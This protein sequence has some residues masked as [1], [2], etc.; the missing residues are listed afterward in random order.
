MRGKEGIKVH[1]GGG[2]GGV[3]CC[4]PVS[5]FSIKLRGKF[6]KTKSSTFKH[7]K[8]FWFLTFLLSFYESGQ[9]AHWLVQFVQ[10]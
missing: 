5:K 4:Q 2:L 9:K 6:I 8:C 3:K 10:S 1:R 7:M